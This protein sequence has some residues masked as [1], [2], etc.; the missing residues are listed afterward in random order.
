MQDELDFK[1]DQNIRI[2]FPKSHDNRKWKELNAEL[3]LA[4]PEAFSKAFIRRSDSNTLVTKFDGFLHS[5]FL[6]NC[7]AVDEHV[8]ATP[9]LPSSKRH[10]RL[11]LS[12][13][14]LAGRLLGF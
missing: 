3:T 5:F 7:G 8:P 6:E 4:L 12:K 14:V 2:D 9:K 10:R 13:R 1:R 11:E